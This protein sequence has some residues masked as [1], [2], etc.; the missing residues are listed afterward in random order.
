MLGNKIEKLRMSRLIQN[1]RDTMYTYRFDEGITNEIT[2]K[3]N[4][5]EL[6]NQL[7]SIELHEESENIEIGGEDEKEYTEL[8]NKEV[9]LNSRITAIQF[10]LDNLVSQKHQALETF[11]IEQAGQLGHAIIK[12]Q[13]ELGKQE[14]ELSIHLE[15]M[16]QIEEN[17]EKKM[18]QVRLNQ[19]QQKSYETVKNYFNTLDKIQIDKILQTDQ[20]LQP[21]LGEYF[22]KLVKE[23]NQ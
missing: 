20:T 13:E 2:T 22:E 9:E 1:R 15:K 19:L 10:E 17:R 16:V 3:A 7:Q 21:I 14:Q 6:H 18:S 5:D 12:L 23:M 4:I 11:N 8:A